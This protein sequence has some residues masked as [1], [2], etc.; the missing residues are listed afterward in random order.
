MQPDSLAPE[1]VHQIACSLETRE[2]AVSFA[3]TCQYVYSILSQ[4]HLQ[5]IE[6]RSPLRMPSLWARLSRDDMRAS[7]VRSLTVLPEDTWDIDSVTRDYFDLEEQIPQEYRECSAND[8][9]TGHWNVDQKVLQEWQEELHAALER[10][11][12]LRQFRWLRSV[13]PV[14]EGENDLWTRLQSLGTVQELQVLDVR[15]A[16]A[17]GWP[18]VV[19]S[20]SFQSFRG[21]TSF[22]LQ[23]DETDNTD[24]DPDVTPLLRM[25]VVNCPGLEKLRLHLYLLRHIETANADLLVREG[26]WSNLESLYLEGFNC[27]PSDLSL[28]LFHH[29]AL[30]ELKLPCMMPGHGWQDLTL[31]PGTLPNLHT[32]ECHS[33]TAA[34]VLRD[35]E[36]ASRLVRLRGID[37]S[38]TV[39]LSAYFKWDF[40][41]EDEHELEEVDL[42]AE[43]P[44]PWKAK[45]LEGIRTHTSIVSLELD[46]EPSHSQLAE[47]AEVAPQITELSFCGDYDVKGAECWREARHHSPRLVPLFKD[48]DQLDRS[49]E[50]VED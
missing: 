46:K 37:L 17:S 7:V 19:A 29:P 32:L 12:C 38:D 21:L 5:Y 18:S 10:M 13:P 8:H 25:L 47:L 30:R 3:L 34:A 24:D 22:Y 33:P 40:E 35:S 36:V 15:H 45:L 28:F 6:I 31:A 26:L 42:N 39:C 50:S 11:K 43:I 48:T 16:R 20:P 49:R 41:W 1:L 27:R 4:I 2:D 9:G 23:T 14:S 44:S